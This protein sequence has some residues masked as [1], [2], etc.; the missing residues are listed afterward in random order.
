[1]TLGSLVSDNGYV[2]DLLLH[3]IVDWSLDRC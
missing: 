3:V 1:M 2:I